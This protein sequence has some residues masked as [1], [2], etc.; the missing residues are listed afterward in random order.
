MQC[1]K[2]HVTSTLVLVDPLVGGASHNITAKEFHAAV[3]DAIVPREGRRLE[4]PTA[5]GK[6]SARDRTR[7]GAS[8]AHVHMY[9]SLLIHASSPASN[10]A[11]TFWG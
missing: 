9:S 8:R 5:C 7:Q 3:L 10:P 6:A 1:K 11:V 2:A 4:A